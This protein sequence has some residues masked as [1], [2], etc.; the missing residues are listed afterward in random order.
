MVSPCSC[1]SY[2]PC[3]PHMH[4]EFEILNSYVFYFCTSLWTLHHITF[5]DLENFPNC[6]SKGVLKKLYKKRDTK[7]ED[8]KNDATVVLNINL[9]IKVDPTSKPL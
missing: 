1:G 5:F 2:M 4:Y 7:Q 9:E 6:E 3:F 8:S